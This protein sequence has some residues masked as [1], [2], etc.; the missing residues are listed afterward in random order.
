MTDNIIFQKIWQD[1]GLIE[2]KITAIGEYVRACQNCYV[3]KLFLEGLAGD[4]QKYM[5]HYDKGY[6]IE[7]GKKEG[8]FTPSFSMEFLPADYHG[9]VKIEVDVEIADNDSRAHRCLF[10]INSELG[11]I[12]ELG[13]SLSQLPDKEPGAMCALYND[14]NYF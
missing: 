12:E 10:Y 1:E 3:E 2:L 5:S 14:S 11:T 8:N 7:F 13:K 4:F 6:Y 9:H